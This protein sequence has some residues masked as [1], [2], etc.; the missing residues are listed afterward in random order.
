[1]SVSVFKHLAEVSHELRSLPHLLL[2]LDLDGTLAPI[3]SHARD[4]AIPA[5]TRRILDRL[6][7]RSDITI[8]IV[9]G[10]ALSDLAPLVGMDVVL[11]G[12]HG[13]EISGPE[14]NFVHPQ[15]ERTREKVQQVCAH[16]SSALV[17]I[18]GAWV[19]NKG[20]TAS[21]HFRNTEASRQCEVARIVREAVDMRN[22][23]LT[24]RQGNQVLEILP[25]TY[26]NKG[27]A[28][29]WILDHI[30][31]KGTGLCYVGDDVTDEDVFR[32]LAG[33]TVR[34]GANSPTAAR[35]AARD[36]VE[37]AEFLRWIAALPGFNAS[38]SE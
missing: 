22:G 34:V 27:C 17:L 9:S 19:E 12:N 33:V 32:M 31:K 35:F 3:V 20:L 13:M 1:L 18:P 7:A 6:A 16:L 26:W 8:A 25:Q 15:A 10:R 29:R 37:V 21:V 14:M 5:G 2:G 11:A 36:T 24:I 28:V 23:E 38:R 4:S 30:E